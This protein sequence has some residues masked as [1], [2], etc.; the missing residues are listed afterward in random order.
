MCPCTDRCKVTGYLEMYKERE[1]ILLKP[2]IPY[3]IINWI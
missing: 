2:I 1:N 3:M